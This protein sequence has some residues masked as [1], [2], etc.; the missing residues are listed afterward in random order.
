MLVSRFMTRN[1]TTVGP[2][3]PVGEAVR[4]MEDHGFRHLPVEQSGELVGLVS[5]RDVQLGTGGMSLEELGLVDDLNVV[6]W[7]RDVMRA[8]VIC[9]ESAERGAVAAAR[10]IEQHVGALPVPED[11][12][13]VGIVT[14]TN[15]V[16]AYYDL[17]RDP[18]NADALDVTIEGVMHSVVVSM[19]PSDTVSQAIRNCT[20]WRIRHIPVLD[21]DDELVGIVSDRDIRMAVGRALVADAEA[22][23]DGRVYVED[24][25]VGDIMS[26]EVLTIEP[27]EMLSAAVPIMLDNRVSALPVSLEGMMMGIITRT[28]VLEHYG[29]VA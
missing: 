24:Q 7:V 20:D 12:R 14:E 9:V 18:A 4:L 16:K 29:S 10:M 2:D 28:D 11:G 23:R 3:S 13:L 17:C 26:T 15:L 6:H 21:E 1:P 22:Q 19:S 25:R 8:P 27:T 5:D